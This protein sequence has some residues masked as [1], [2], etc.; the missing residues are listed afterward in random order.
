MLEFLQAALGSPWLWLLVFAVSALDALLPFMPSETAVV[1]LAVLVGLDFGALALLAAVAAAGAFGGDLLS[2]GIGRSAGPAVVARLQ[3][4]EKG[5]RRY[6]WARR[7]VTERGAL[8]IVAARYLP[9]GRV[10]TG[11]ATGSMRYPLRRFIALDALGAAL[12]AVYSVLIGLLGGAQFGGEPVK[13]LLL[14]FGIGLAVVAALEVAR[15]A[16]PGRTGK[17]GQPCHR[18]NAD[19]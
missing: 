10:A 3:R 11:L 14:A 17:D 6:A 4:G 7:K 2:H 1:G 15:R 13:G 12:W 5:A 18:Q 16:V 8:L 9:G 19:M